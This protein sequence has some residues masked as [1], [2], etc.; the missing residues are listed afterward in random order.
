MTFYEVTLIAT[1]RE[2]VTVLARDVDEAA[3]LALDLVPERSRAWDVE[4]ICIGE[5][6][7]M[8]NDDDN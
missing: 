7:N 1:V 2:T 8:F 5:A 3:D 4:D 6:L